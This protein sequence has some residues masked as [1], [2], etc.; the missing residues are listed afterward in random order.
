MRSMKKKEPHFHENCRIC[1]KTF[2]VYVSR[3]A[4][5]RGRYCSRQCAT[6][7]LFKKG[8]RISPATEFKKGQMP[9][10]FKGFSYSIARSKGKP[11]KLIYSPHHPY[12]TKRKTVREHRLIMEQ[13]LGRYL[14]RDEIVHHING[15]TLDNRV[16]NLQIMAK[17][18]HDRMNVKLNVHKRWQ[19]GVV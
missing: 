18:D 10:G 14:R 7:T 5:G 19:R 4:E 2:L 13:M 17:R 3:R 16:E 15:D 8:Y 11:Y 6:E 9:S 12:A 1:G